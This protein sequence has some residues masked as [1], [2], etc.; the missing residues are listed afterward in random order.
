M[1]DGALGLRRAS[2]GFSALAVPDILEALGA[3]KSPLCSPRS[4]GEPT[5]LDIIKAFA[6]LR[7]MIHFRP[8]ITPRNP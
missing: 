4:S 6:P 2:T 5:A 3:P 8:V 1:S 7:G